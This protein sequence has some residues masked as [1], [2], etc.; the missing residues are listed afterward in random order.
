MR[1]IG[2]DEDEIIGI[3]TSHNNDQRQEIAEQYEGMYGSGLVDDL[4]SELRDELQAVIEAL[5]DKPALYDAKELRKAM[6]GPGTD[7]TILIEILCTRTNI[8]LAAIR[9]A[10]HAHFDRE[11]VEDLQSE[12]AGS[13][14]KLL[15]STA[16]GDRDEDEDVDLDSAGEDAQA[17]F[18]AADGLFTDES[19]FNLILCTRNYRHLKAVFVAFHILA[20]KQI[21]ECIREETAG[22]TQD[23]YL[24]IVACAR[25]MNEFLAD[26]IRDSLQG[27]G[28]DDEALIRQIVSRAETDLADVGNSYADK[29]GCSLHEAVD[30]ECRGDYKNA[31]LAIVGDA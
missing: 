24:T 1:G 14:E 2:S 17:M 29:H 21:E 23:A 6:R 10:Y 11:L 31:M 3:I 12:A 26:R 20:E 30:G 9:I 16:T 19:T 15:V 7:D 18:D 13:F 8:Q 5:M 28:T 25:D 27:I 4:K 22:A